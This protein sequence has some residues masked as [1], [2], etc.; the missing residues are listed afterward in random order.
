MWLS[1]FIHTTFINNKNKL[2]YRY[3]KLAIYAAIYTF[4]VSV[5]ILWIQQT[6]D[7]D[8][9]KVDTNIQARTLEVVPMDIG[10]DTLQFIFV[11]K[12]ID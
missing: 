9:E 8:Y 4:R 10:V 11:M 6:M 2:T 12:F 7:T 5:K 1:F 3:I